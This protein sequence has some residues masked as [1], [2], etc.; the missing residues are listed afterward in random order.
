MSISLCFCFFILLSVFS[1][2]P[3]AAGE[4]EITLIHIGDLHGHLISRP[5]MRKGDPD[6]GEPV[7]G[8]AYVYDQI[9]KIRA[10]HPHSLLINTGD[11][12]QGGAEAL[13]SSGGAMAEILNEWKIDAFAPGNWDYLYGTERFIELFAGTDEQ[14]P[15]APWGALSANLYYATLYEFPESRYADKAGTR[16]LP[17][18]VIKKVNGLKIGIAGLTAERGPQAVSTRVMDGFFLTPG[19]EELQ[20]IIKVFREE[21]QVDLA[22][23]ISERGLAGNLE[24]TETYPGIDVVLSSDMHEETY[25]IVQAASGTLLVE[26]G[27]DGTMLGELNIKLAERKI[28]SYTWT[29]HRINHRNNQ[30]DPETEARI[31]RIRRP[32][33]SG[34]EFIPHVNPVNAAVLRTPINTIIGHT[35]TALHRSDFSDS[36]T[37]AVIEGSSHNFLADAFKNACESD[38]GM[39]RGFRYGT[40]IAPGAITLEDIYHFIPI[41]PQVACGYMSGD[42]L[43]EQVK[44]AA[45]G[46]LTR[47]VGYWGGGWILAHAGLRYDLDP[48]NEFGH[49]VS[50]LRVNGDPIDLEK[51]YSVAGYWYLENPSWINRF[52]AEKLRILKNAYGGVVDA[53]EI[54]AYYLQSLPDKTADTQTGRVRLLKPLPKPIAGNREIQPL[55]GI[56]RPDY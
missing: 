47:F 14:A 30:P 42:Q 12:I 8:L 19:E 5:N 54:I 11:T 52:P 13:Y 9:K 24:L 16:V 49:R 7:G 53:T 6:Y 33:I 43:K 45:D 41:G 50:N 20:E 46:S 22:V 18:Y 23:L 38:I 27:Q 51:M 25:Q 35:K 55:K 1:V 32:F 26:E 40:H 44:K 10:Q 29:A 48:Y 39:M 34:A 28:A 21:E 4:G 36:E 2:L 15:L 31:Q 37:P 17:A 3:A 56:P